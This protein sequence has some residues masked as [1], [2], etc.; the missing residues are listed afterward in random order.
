MPQLRLEEITPKE[1]RK[2][3]RS[4]T[5]EPKDIVAEVNY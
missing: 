5:P 1:E 3:D 4:S 2:L